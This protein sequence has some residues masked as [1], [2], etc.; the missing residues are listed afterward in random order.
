MP[1]P[2]LPYDVLRNIFDDIS[3]DKNILKRCSLVCRSWT[4]PTGP[5]L[6]RSLRVRLLVTYPIERLLRYLN[7]CALHSERMQAF[8]QEC[9][10]EGEVGVLEKQLDNGKHN[11]ELAQPECPLE[12]LQEL[13]GILPHLQSLRISSV[14]FC[15]NPA[16]PSVPHV[17]F[18]NIERLHLSSNLPISRG[19]ASNIFLS[20][21][22]IGELRIERIATHE[23]E[24]NAAEIPRVQVQRLVLCDLNYHWIFKRAI[25]LLCDTLDFAALTSL[26]LQEIP[27]EC[28]SVFSQL[29][30][31]CH[32]I[33]TLEIGFIS[34]PCHPGGPPSNCTD[35]RGLHRSLCAPEFFDPVVDLSAC[36]KLCQLRLSRVVLSFSA[37]TTDTAAESN[38]ASQALWN[39]VCNLLSSI[40]GSSNVTAVEIDVGLRFS[41][42]WDDE[43]WPERGDGQKYLGMTNWKQLDANLARLERLKSVVIN[44]NEYGQRGEEFVCMLHERLSKE[45]RQRTHV[46]RRLEYYIDPWPSDYLDDQWLLEVGPVLVSLSLSRLLRYICR[47]TGLMLSTPSGY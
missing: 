35:T 7:E 19:R 23:P 36:T 16:S 34:G 47:G 13:I 24:L 14:V 18:K 38:L 21:A 42:T 2:T 5:F 3:D 39:F 28:I 17:S 30:L 10:F 45:V 8:L 37:K 11:L 4:L 29:L 44:L 41:Q 26:H 46:H 6:F 1:A 12:V 25:D 20:F 40:P 27:P 9:I 22:N 33:D 15:S 32:A 31:N 43:P